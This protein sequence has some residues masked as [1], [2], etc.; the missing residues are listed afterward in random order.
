MKT[1]QE[2]PATIITT[3]QQRKLIEH[4]EQQHLEDGG[5]IL[6][7]VFHDGLRIRVLTKDQTAQL[8]PVISAAMGRPIDQALRNSAFYKRAGG[9]A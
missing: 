6:A 8:V 7:Q 4:L 5:S 3:P 1:P 9:A 2:S